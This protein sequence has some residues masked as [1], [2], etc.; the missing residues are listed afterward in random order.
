MNHSVDTANR[1][2]DTA[3]KKNYDTGASFLREAFKP[4]SK[5]RDCLNKEEKEQMEINK[6][7]LTQRLKIKKKVAGIDTPHANFQKSKIFQKIPKKGYQK[8]QKSKILF[9]SKN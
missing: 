8:C 1:V 3:E 5:A 9:F 7:F 6:S 2:Y 4:K